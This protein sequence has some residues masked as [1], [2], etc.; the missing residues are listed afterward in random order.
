MALKHCLFEKS[1]FRYDTA[2]LANTG[3][4]L[5]CI[6]ARGSQNLDN[7]DAFG[8]IELCA[9]TSEDGGKTWSAATTIAAPPARQ[10]SLQEGNMKSS[11]FLNPC[12]TAT[13]N[14]ELLLLA[15]FFPES[16]GM[17]EEKLLDKKKVAYAGFDGKT[18]PLI[19]DRDGNYFMVL[20][21][22]TVLD[23]KKTKTAYR[24]EGFGELYRED[25]YLG[26]IYLNGAMGKSDNENKTTFGAP[27]KAPKRSYLL[28]FTSR[29]NGK[30]GARR[31]ISPHR[32]CMR[33]TAFYSPLPAVAD[34]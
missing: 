9:R 6:T 3:S 24:V 10:N 29:D 12:L 23:A 32:C 33:T 13:E 31:Q 5:V 8:H 11:F 34:W 15:T 20:P 27:L 17:A 22:G 2:G 16:L 7:G 25:E 26:N 1:D 30:V 21:D 19:Y 4:A 18:Y 28:Q 14:G